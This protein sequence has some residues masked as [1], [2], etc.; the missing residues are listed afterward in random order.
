MYA[1]GY[2]RIIDGY[3]DSLAYLQIG[4]QVGEW[5]DV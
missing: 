1:Y 3:L 5:M 4:S 2:K